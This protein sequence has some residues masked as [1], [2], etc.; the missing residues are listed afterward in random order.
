MKTGDFEQ[1]KDFILDKNTYFS[2]GF[3]NA[4]KDAE[5]QAIVV[6]DGNEMKRLLPDVRKQIIST[7]GM[8]P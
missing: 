5:I 3:A 1:L 6:K 7:S 4:V 2:T 8:R